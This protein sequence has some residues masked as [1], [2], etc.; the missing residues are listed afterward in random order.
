MSQYE[1]DQSYGT[2]PTRK[3]DAGK[4]WAGGLATALVAAGVGVAGVLAIRGLLKI[5]ILSGR[6]QL[7]NEAILTVPIAAA[8]A[9]LIATGLLN[10]LMISTPRPSL[11]FNSLAGVVLVV[12]VLLVFLANA[13]DLA[14]KIATAALYLL[15]GLVIMGLLTG[16]ARTAIKVVPP[17]QYMPPG[18]G[19]GPYPDQTQVM[20]PQQQGGYDQYGQGGSDRRDYY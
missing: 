18:R 4:L 19:P 15:I 16:V 11:F 5:A 3:V 6:G 20:P 14:D 7:V 10:L 12:M 17:A 2:E 13:G 8:A 9:A 1:Y